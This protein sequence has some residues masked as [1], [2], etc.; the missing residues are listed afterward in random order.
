MAWNRK[1]ENPIPYSNH[2]LLKGETHLAF[3]GHEASLVT[4]HITIFAT[5]K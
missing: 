3:T 2:R 5:R 1:M 4:K